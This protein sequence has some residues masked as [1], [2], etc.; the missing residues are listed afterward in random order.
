MITYETYKFLH[1]FFI[2]CFFMAAALTAFNHEILNSKWSKILISLLSFLIFVAGMGLIARLHFKHT[3]PFPSWIR[4]K[5]ANWVFLNAI[6]IYSLKTNQKSIKNL[7][8]YLIPIS[9][10]LGIWLAINKPI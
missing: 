2:V 6:L 8:K 5:I 9:A 4:L 10:G 1:L 7:I 3:E